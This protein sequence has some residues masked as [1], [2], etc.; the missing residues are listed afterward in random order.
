MNNK[1][2]FSFVEVLIAIS[3]IV[4]LAVISINSSSKYGENRDNSKVVSDL[5]T[6]DN[7]LES[8]SS[9]E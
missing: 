7:A 6:I 9:V 2:A 3:I 4:L 5:A 1:Q 8:Y